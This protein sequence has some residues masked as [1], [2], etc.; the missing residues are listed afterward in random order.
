MS[1]EKEYAAVGKNVERPDARAKVTGE[2]VF[3]VD[4]QL[5]HMLYAKFLR[6]PHA[7]AKVIS[8]KAE[9][10]LALEGVYGIVWQKD[11]IGMPLLADVQDDRVR[12]QGEAVAGV[13]AETEEIAERAVRLLEAEYEVYQGALDMDEAAREGAEKIWPQGNYCLF[14]DGAGRM[15]PDM[16]WEKGD[17][18]KG[19]EESDVTAELWAETHSQYH[20]CLEPHTCVMHWREGMRELDCWISTQTMYDDRNVLAQIMGT[21][22]DKVHIVCP[23][24]GGGFGGLFRLFAAL[25]RIPSHPLRGGA[26]GGDS[27]SLVPVGAEGGQLPR[28]IRAGGGVFAPAA[29]RGDDGI[30]QRLPDLYRRPVCG[31][32]LSGG[33]VRL[34]SPPGGEP[35][36]GPYRGRQSPV[37]PGV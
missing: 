23:F 28:T 14:P 21:S 18:E 24:V 10:A 19:M 16:A 32:V 12:Y 5:P 15:S 8:V 6:S 29:H 34:F 37:Q 13:A 25:A 35:A 1:K 7:Y 17:A 36:S 31:G 20:V 33:G 27:H 26:G 11:L 3:T 22:Q 30:S 4:V 2:A 9:K